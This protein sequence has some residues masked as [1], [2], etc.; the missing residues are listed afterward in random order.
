ME[1][2]VFTQLDIRSNP[3]QRRLRKTHTVGFAEVRRVRD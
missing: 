2:N 1:P 3:L